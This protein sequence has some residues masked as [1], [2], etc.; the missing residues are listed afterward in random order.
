MNHAI[1]FCLK[2][3]YIIKKK[4]E[5]TYGDCERYRY[6]ERRQGKRVSLRGK[7]QYDIKKPQTHFTERFGYLWTEQSVQGRRILPKTKYGFGFSDKKNQNGFGLDFGFGNFRIWFCIDF[8]SFFY[9]KLFLGQDK[10][11][12]WQKEKKKKQS[13]GIFLNR[14]LNIIFL[15]FSFQDKVI[16]CLEKWNW[17]TL[18]FSLSF[19]FSLRILEV[20]CS[21]L[22]NLG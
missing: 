4:S 21:W 16:L 14:I 5:L 8:V 7:R 12:Q 15:C 18:L 22:G 17:I 3:K 19:P 13:M 20:T 9:L 10:V 2:N 11:G 1:S 6:S